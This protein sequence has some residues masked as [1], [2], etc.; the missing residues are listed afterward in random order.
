M[1]SVSTKDLL[2]ARRNA[3]RMRALKA[4]ARCRSGKIK[5]SDYRPCKNCTETEN[6]LFC[7]KLKNGQLTM[8]NKF[9]DQKS[10]PE[11]NE[12]DQLKTQ[13]PFGED[14]VPLIKGNHFALGASTNLFQLELKP[15]LPVPTHRLVSSRSRIP[16]CGVVQDFDLKSPFLPMAQGSLFLSSTVPAMCDLP[17]TADGLSSTQSSLLMRSQSSTFTTSWLPPLPHLPE[18]L[19]SPPTTTLPSFPALADS[20]AIDRL[21]HLLALAGGASPS[22]HSMMHSRGMPRR[23][24]GLPFR[25]SRGTIELAVTGAPRKASDLL[26]L[27][28]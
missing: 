5:C 13:A 1:H 2:Q 19:A 3:K 12:T 14:L 26:A 16:A 15:K 21:H 18:H 22:A 9:R 23:F 17:R 11:S 6:G 20:L 8:E 7:V 25:A 4:C 27:A 24:G 28:C 10:I